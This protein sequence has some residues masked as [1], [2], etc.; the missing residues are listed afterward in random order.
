M[1]VLI[2]PTINRHR[3]AYRAAAAAVSQRRGGVLMTQLHDLLRPTPFVR[4]IDEADFEAWNGFPQ[5]SSIREA[6]RCENSTLLTDDGSPSSSDGVVFIEPVF[7][8]PRLLIVGGGHVGQAVAREAAQVGFEVSVLD[9]RNEFTRPELFPDGTLMCCGEIRQT[10]EQIHFTPDTYVVVV[11]RGHQHDREALSACLG[12]PT[13]YLGMIGSKR[14]VAL[15]RKFFLDSGTSEAEF[16]RVYAPIGLDIGA[17]TVPEIATSI[18]SQLISVRR[19][20]TASRM[21]KV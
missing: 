8:P 1:R 6:Y 13:T 17:V 16:D 9:D 7:P 2:D 4:W 11:S 10:L 18:V 3:D 5:V 19:K 20:G 12:K 21:P 14:K 15:V